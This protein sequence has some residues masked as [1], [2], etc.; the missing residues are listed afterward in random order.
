MITNVLKM[1]SPCP[2]GLC[3]WTAAIRMTHKHSGL[4]RSHDGYG[5]ASAGCLTLQSLLKLY[6][7][8]HTSFT[9]I[10]VLALYLQNHQKPLLVGEALAC[11]L[12]GFVGRS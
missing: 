5:G 3:G 11:R 7:H 9:C 12:K 1:V 6:I 2:P 4:R 10:V 8:S